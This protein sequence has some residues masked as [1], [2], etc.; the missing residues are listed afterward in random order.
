MITSSRPDMQLQHCH[1][2]P[3]RISTI[4]TQDPLQRKIESEMLRKQGEALMSAGQMMHK[5]ADIIDAY[6]DS[7]AG[8]IHDYMILL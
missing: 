3:A 2:R 7:I 4:L 8:E 1:A 5:Q 6:V